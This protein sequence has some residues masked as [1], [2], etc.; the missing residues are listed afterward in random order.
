[1]LHKRL[2]KLVIS[3]LASEVLND[4]DTDFKALLALVACTRVSP[5]FNYISRQFL[6]KFHLKSARSSCILLEILT[7][8]PYICTY[9]HAL[10]VVL[11]NPS[12]GQLYDPMDA[13][14]SRIL[15]MLGDRRSGERN[16]R[17]LE[18]YAVDL[19][20]HT[21]PVHW[22]ARSPEFLSSVDKLIKSKSL[23]WVGISELSAPM[24]L[25]IKCAS[26]VENL[27]IRRVKLCESDSGSGTSQS[28]EGP[29]ICLTIR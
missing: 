8:N 22:T 11:R 14:I 20:L 6:K 21:G 17:C 15:D 23:T 9:V 24:D 3:N 28:L 5:E 29:N 12:N 1:M 13:I 10:K 27:T 16:F 19:D 26:N 18:I 7:Q 4:T 2:L 25:I